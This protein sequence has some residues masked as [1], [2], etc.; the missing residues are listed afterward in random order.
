[1]GRILAEE[2]PGVALTLSSDIAPEIREYERT[3]TAL[4]NVYVQKIAERYLG[5][6]EQRTR[7]RRSATTAH[8][9][10]MQSNGGL[11]SAEQASAMPVRLVESGPGGGR[12]GGGVLWAGAGLAR[13]P[14][15]R[16]GGHHRQS[17]P[18]RQG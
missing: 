8:L 10:V 9:Y 11:I 14:V 2:L 18:H 17:L 6:L 15:L 1:M 7:T 16:H 13:H 4:C 12:A 3:S 5:R